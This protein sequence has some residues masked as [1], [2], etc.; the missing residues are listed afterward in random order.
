MHI[1][2]RGHKFKLSNNK[3]NAL[4][5]CKGLGW[6]LPGSLCNMINIINATII[7]TFLNSC[8]QNLRPFPRSQFSLMVNIVRPTR[9][10]VSDF[11]TKQNDYYIFWWLFIK[12]M[13][14]SFVSWNDKNL[15]AKL[16]GHLS[17]DRHF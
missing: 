12:N 5:S 11:P 4:R 15:S 6:S 10:I 7:K 8:W 3:A 13:S 2:S 16:S 14:R 17:I 1:F 9:R